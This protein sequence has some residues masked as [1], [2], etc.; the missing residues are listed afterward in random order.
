MPEGRL[1]RVLSRWRVRAAP[2]ALVLVLAFARPTPRSLLVCCAFGAAGLAVRAWASG[3]LK[4]DKELAVSGPYRYT[5]NPLYLGNLLLGL[6]LA[7]GARTWASL[8]VFAAYFLVFYS[9][10]VLRERRRM[11]DLFPGG[12]AAYR[13]RVPLFFPSLRRAGPS[14]VRFDGRLYLKNKEYRAL[15]GFAAVGA[16]LLARMLLRG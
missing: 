9:A 13:S 14:S 1:E 15:A 16:L 11:K 7:L 2:V 12:Y 4:K 5:R 3:H 6:G 8:A 10:A